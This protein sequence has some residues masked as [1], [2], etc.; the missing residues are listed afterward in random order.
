MLLRQCQVA[1]KKAGY[2]VSDKIYL[3]VD[4]GKELQDLIIREKEMFESE[5]LA[6]LTTDFMPDYHEDISLDNHHFT[7]N[8]KVISS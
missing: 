8:L 6:S 1:R 7:I 5:L 2:K 3:K 4:C